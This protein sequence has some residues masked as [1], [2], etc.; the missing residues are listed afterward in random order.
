MS[1]YLSATFWV[2]LLYTAVMMSA[3]LLIAS[4]GELFAEKSGVLNLGIEGIMITGAS[5]GFI[6]S[7]LTKSNFLGV[8]GGATIGFILGLIFAFLVTTLELDQILTGIGVWIAGIGLGTLF[9][10]EVNGVTTGSRIQTMGAFEIPLLSRLPLL[11]DILFS[12]NLLVY[13]SF[14]LVPIT[15]FIFYKTSFGLRIRAVGEN[16]EAADSRG[17][18]VHRTRQWCV[19]IGGI[20]AGIAGAYLPLAYVGSYSHMMTAGRGFMAIAVVIFANWNPSKTILG[21][22]IFSTSIAFQIRLRAV[23]VDIAAP[24]LHMIPYIVTLV[25][26]V[27][28]TRRAGAP[29]A[30]TKPFIKKKGS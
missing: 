18:N 7:F 28:I 30:L 26:L 3:P 22:L 27:I 21:A 13:F 20:L 23:G 9:I 24:L 1:Y 14:I 25:A 16:P 15:A 29:S 11:G 6:V 8:L 5:V 12:Q 19:I 4:I 2:P 10:H 17:I